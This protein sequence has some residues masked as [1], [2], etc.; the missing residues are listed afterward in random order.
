MDEFWICDG[1]RSLNRSKS[2]SCYSCKLPRGARATPPST[3]SQA[4]GG[5]SAP[6]QGSY[7]PTPL[8]GPPLPPDSPQQP[9]AQRQPFAQQPPFAAQPP[10]GQQPPFAAQQPPFSQQPPFAQ[11]PPPPPR[12][13][14]GAA[15][16]PPTQFGQ[17][18]VPFSGYPS[19]ASPGFQPGQVPPSIAWAPQPAASKSNA[20]VLSVILGLAMVVVI[21]AGAII[22]FAPGTAKSSP[23]ALVAAGTATPTPTPTETPTPTPTP[24]PSVAL[25]PAPKGYQQLVSVESG[26]ALSIPSGWVY[27]SEDLPDSLADQKAALSSTYPNLASLIDSETVLLGSTYRL[28]MFDPTGGASARKTMAGLVAVLAPMGAE[29]LTAASVKSE[30]A[31]FGSITGVTATSVKEPAGPTIKAVGTMNASGVAVKVL[32]YLV[33]GKNHAFVVVFATTSAAFSA[34]SKTFDQIVASIQDIALP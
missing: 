14:Y 11:Q 34:Y 3:T 4:G 32:A 8:P 1:C 27:V 24:R 19:A 28:A 13:L 30:L 15:P 12:P 21:G 6:S 17:A 20:R 31:S 2:S 23:A 33:A 7:R 22:A 18:T 26:Y 29:D 25:T 9:F 5:S 16:Q 10:A